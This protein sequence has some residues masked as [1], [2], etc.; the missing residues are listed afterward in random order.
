ML[1][2][3]EQRAITL[4]ALVITIIVM[5]ILA[6]V[7]ISLTLKDN[8][9]FS[10]AKMA[11][12]EYKRAEEEEKN[13]IEDAYGEI[14]LATGDDAKVT[15]SMKDLNTLIK[16]KIAEATPDYANGQEIT[17][18][19]KT[20]TAENDGYIQLRFNY[21][22]GV[23]DVNDALYINERLVFYNCASVVWQNPCTPIFQVKKGDVIRYT[24]RAQQVFGTYYPY[25]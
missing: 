12:N 25:R 15:I 23:S 24:N 11:V 22:A 6:G 9:I 1:K 7:A 18:T 3:R 21:T 13:E 20:Y 5:V 17:F 19:N 16:N 4:I 2:T 10:K 8:G 14:M